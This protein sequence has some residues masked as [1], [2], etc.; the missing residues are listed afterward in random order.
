MVPAAAADELLVGE[1][2][3]DAERNELRRGSESV[4][5][6]PKAIEVLRQL[7]LRPGRVVGREEL[8]AL[9]W[10]GV[11][12][13]DD[14]L[15]Q[16]II[17]LRKALGDDAQNPRYI[18]TIPK[19]GYRLVATAESQA[20]GQAGHGPA[21]GGSRRFGRRARLAV[22]VLLVFAL[23]WVF[24]TST[25]R[26]RSGAPAAGNTRQ[27]TRAEAFPL[28]AVLPLANLSGDP[29]RD[30]LSDGIT[31]DIIDALGRFSG[32]RVMS[33]NA[34]QTFKGQEPPE[35]RAVREMLASRYVVRGSLREAEGTVRVAIELSD[36]ERGVQLWSQRYDARGAQL[37]EMQ[38]RIVTNIVGALAVKLTDIEQQRAFTQ[39]TESAQAYD[40][41]LRARALLS[42]DQRGA[43]R[44]ARTLLGR[45]QQMA[46][47]YADAW[48]VAGE[49]EWERAAFGWIEDPAEGVRRARE[50][51]RR[52]LDLPDPRAHGRAYGLLAA[53]E[54]HTGQ[55]ESALLHSGRAVSINPSDASALFR[56]AHAL[57]VLGRADEAITTF[58]TAMRYEPRPQTGPRAQLLTA[59]YTARRY[60]DAVAYADML[61]SLRPES[62]EVHAVRAAALA[63]LGHLDEAGRSADAVRRLNPIFS[64]DDAGTR[65]RNP[66][67]A[68]K[69][70]EGLVKAGL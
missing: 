56:H 5:L 22:G 50:L 4:H 47:G 70:R 59:Y 23:L 44:E 24:T 14:A 30:Y 45:A 58:E 64:V 16:A 38:D 28:V 26:E 43:N 10:P 7:A 40:L 8:L 66:E 29:Q 36:A 62:Y 15:T 2:I 20:A 46:P 42:L 67:H 41:V 25:L 48:I 61:L 60:S 69:L 52:A 27:T 37:F 31:A 1:W 32:V 17:K 34:V 6:E 63:Q 12:V 3:L 9:V 68:A 57:L 39:P 53:L 35:A 55:H 19:R 11:V 18:E 51:A 65:F 33:W 21:I 49:A 13:G 54:A